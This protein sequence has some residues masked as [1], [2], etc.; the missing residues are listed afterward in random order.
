MPGRI[1]NLAAAIGAGALIAVTACTATPAGPTAAGSA[2]QSPPGAAAGG[3]AVL[4]GGSPYSKVLIIAEENKAYSRIIGSADAPYVNKLAKAYGTAKNMSAGY[5]INCPSL[6]A[7]VLLSSGSTHGICDDSDAVKHRLTGDNI[8][9]QVAKSGQRWRSYAESMPTNCRPTNTG[10]GVYVVRHAP[11]PYFV[12]ETQSGRCKNWHVPLGSLT[13]GALRDDVVEGTLPAYSFV[14]PNACDDMHGAG[15]CKT[16]LVRKGDTWLSQW[17]PRILAGRDYKAGRLVV[18]VLWDEG[19]ATDNH[20]PALI[21]S[22]TTVKVASATHFTHCS[23]L[24]TVEE[25]LG[26]PL[27]NCAQQALSMRQDFRL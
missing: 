20:V 26:L 24:R 4:P 1:Q 21:L 8:Y 6:A 5:A 16:D 22:P 3:G 15:K 18:F 12:T 13:G 23:V 10:D 17:I 14:T 19:N 2:T 25:V 11:A 7:Y 27:L 9:Q